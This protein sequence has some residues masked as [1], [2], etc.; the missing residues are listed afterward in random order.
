[1][2]WRPAGWSMCLPLLIFP[3]TIKSRSSLLTPPGWSRKK[4]RIKR[5]WCGVVLLL[6]LFF[7]H[8]W[9]FIYADFVN[10][11]MIRSCMRLVV[12]LPAAA[13]AKYCDEHVCVCVCVC[14]SVCL[15]V[16]QRISE[17]TCAIFANF[18]VHV[19]YG[20]GLVF[21]GRVITKF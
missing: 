9:Q 21:S 2:E 7:L 12:T 1:M 5:L 6:Y 8:C 17:A 18:S 10:V 16:C 20:R 15:S 13:V 11:S 19:A 3:C 14:V 4:G